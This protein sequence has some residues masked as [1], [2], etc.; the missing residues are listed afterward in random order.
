MVVSRGGLGDSGPPWKEAGLQ[1]CVWDCVVHRSQN[2]SCRA[3]LLCAAF[4][5]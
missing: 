5:F 3:A 2:P 1:G 4:D